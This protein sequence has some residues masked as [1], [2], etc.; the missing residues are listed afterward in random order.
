M[1][2]I[3]CLILSIF[4]ISCSTLSKDEK[5]SRSR[6]L[7]NRASLAVANRD[8]KE[9]N[10]LFARYEGEIGPHFFIP[11]KDDS[12]AVC[13]FELKQ[14]RR[15]ISEFMEQR[16]A[17][18][19]AGLQNFDIEKEASQDSQDFNQWKNSIHK[20]WR[21]CTS[22]YIHGT[23]LGRYLVPYG[24]DLK[25]ISKKF[26]VILEQMEQRHQAYL[27]KIKEENERQDQLA[28]LDE[29]AR[30]AEADFYKTSEGKKKLACDAYREAKDLKEA[31]KNTMAS[32]K[33]AGLSER[34]IAGGTIGY[35]SA[36]GMA[37]N[38]ALE[39]AEQ[40]K[41]LSGKDFQFERDCQ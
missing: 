7:L 14:G 28:K 8:E 35:T 11:C 19:D 25:P 4:W 21:G 2:K 12:G 39:F 29:D 16:L 30:K 5:L 36:F 15:D 34:Q 26:D 6:E 41:K 33:E 38:R 20:D 10:N 24:F 13:R 22:E 40:H 18:C 1:N 27:R 3:I 37:N 23:F 31:H 32:L 9:L 17:R